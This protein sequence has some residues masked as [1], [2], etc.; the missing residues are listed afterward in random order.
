M[1]GGNV[2]QL[3]QEW[4]QGDSDALDRLMPEVYDELRRL[5][6]LQMRG[7]RVDL[8]ILIERKITRCSPNPR[9]T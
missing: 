3:L 8:R 2:T 1:S 5:A 7:E 9:R 4:L 6:S